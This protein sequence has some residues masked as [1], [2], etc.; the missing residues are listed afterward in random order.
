MLKSTLFR[1]QCFN[2]SPNLQYSFY[3]ISSSLIHF[4]LNP[5]NPFL[6]GLQVIFCVKILFLSRVN[7][8]AKWFD[9]CW[10]YSNT[11]WL[12]VV[13]FIYK[14]SS[15]SEVDNIFKFMAHS[16]NETVFMAC[17]VWDLGMWIYCETSTFFIKLKFSNF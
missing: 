6:Q 11:W 1:K 7:C 13:Q 5:L 2:S 16:E 9:I 17:W 15:T 12:S 4:L 10:F 8:S 3:T 14:W